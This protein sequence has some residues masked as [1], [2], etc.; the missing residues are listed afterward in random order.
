MII[1]PRASW[2]RRK[3]VCGDFVLA[4]GLQL[5][6]QVITEDWNIT[7]EILIENQVSFHFTLVLFPVY[8]IKN[9]KVFFN[10]NNVE[11]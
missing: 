3:P 9:I 6:F 5:A 4:R 8:K 7:A 11:S 2:V 10:L 1:S